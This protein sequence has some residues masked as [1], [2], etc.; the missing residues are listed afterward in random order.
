MGFRM[1]FCRARSL[2]SR[3]GPTGPPRDE[4]S[5]GHGWFVGAFAGFESGVA[6]VDFVPV[7]YVPPGGQVF[8]AAV[9]VLQVI[10]VLP[11]VV[12]QDGIEALRDWIILIRCGDDLDFTTGFARQ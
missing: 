7:D 8:R 10:R 11:D 9:V 4:R 2:R 3:D 12:A 5:V 6:L 1:Y